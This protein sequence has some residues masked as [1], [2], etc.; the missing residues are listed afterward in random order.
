MKN[1]ISILWI[2][3][4]PL[5]VLT[6]AFDF[7]AAQNNLPPGAAVT[8]GLK[9]DGTTEILKLVPREGINQYNPVGGVFVTSFPMGEEVK[10]GD[11]GCCW[12]DKVFITGTIA[13][14]LPPLIGFVI[15]TANH[16]TTRYILWF[17]WDGKEYK[18]VLNMVSSS[19]GSPFVDMDRDGD[20]ELLF[21]NDLDEF[22]T[23]PIIYKFDRKLFLFEK[24]NG[25]FPDFWE[26]HIQKDM[27]AL[28]QWKYTRKGTGAIYLCARIA[29][30]LYRRG[31]NEEVDEFLKLADE[32]LN[33]TIEN[34]ANDN[35]QNRA[36]TVREA[37]HQLLQM[38][39][40]SD[41]FVSPNGINLWKH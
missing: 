19:S 4:V 26:S 37:I 11:V 25:R 5:F 3:L 7:A 14:D 8:M 6:L 40:G 15:D 12:D 16:R 23:P 29:S 36:K 35:L 21:K 32:K 39:P 1:K 28:R 2:K 38:A 24:A 22:G 33:P 41:S 9:N 31:G 20:N 18:K 30:Y 13:K 27:G 10:L 34:S 17:M